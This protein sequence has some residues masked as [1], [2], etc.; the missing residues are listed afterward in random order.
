MLDY[1]ETGLFRGRPDAAPSPH[2]RS[3]PVGPPVAGVRRVLADGRVLA[4][5]AVVAV[6]L[7]ILAGTSVPLHS[8]QAGPG[9]PSVTPS[10]APQSPG[11]SAPPSPVPPP[12]APPSTTPPS[13]R[14]S[15]SPGAAGSNGAAPPQARP[16]VTT[17]TTAGASPA[18]SAPLTRRAVQA[19]A[20]A[21]VV[22]TFT[23][24]S[25]GAGVFEGE[26]RI[27]N[28]GTSPLA[29][30]Q[31][32]VALPGDRV[33]AVAN[34]SGFVIHGILLLE[35]ASGATPVPPR[36]GVLNVFFV[37]AGPQPVSGACTYNQ[38][39]CA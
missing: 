8:T 30:W 6:A 32:S 21:A 15:A 35:P 3:R 36:G 10:M 27:V 29:N 24:T 7:A 23:V 34:A 31:V 19:A 11:T 17:G 12:T 16:A 25:R 13:A 14:P 5:A 20:G 1:L 9:R 38:F 39:P 22:V 4:V 37:F 2:R 26:I 18:A 28:D 33:V